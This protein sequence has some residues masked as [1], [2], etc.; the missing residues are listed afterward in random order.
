MLFFRSPTFK[1]AI[2]PTYQK[3]NSIQLTHPSMVFNTSKSILFANRTDPISPNKGINLVLDFP[4]IG[5]LATTTIDPR[6]FASLR[7]PAASIAIWVLILFQIFFAEPLA[8]A[9]VLFRVVLMTL[10]VC[11]I[12]DCMSSMYGGQTVEI[13]WSCTRE[14]YILR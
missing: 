1:A 14:D 2:A 11:K 13:Q 6:I 10:S 3:I 4:G 7:L 12:G 8:L 5:H 9:F